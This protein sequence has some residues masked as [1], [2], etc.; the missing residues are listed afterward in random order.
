MEF[1]VSP[2]ARAVLDEAAIL[3]MRRGKFYVG[4]EYILEAL[5]TRSHLLPAEFAEKHMH[6]LSAAL[7]ALRR[8]EWQG[9]SPVTDTTEVY[10]TPRALDVMHEA[11][12]VAQQFRRG[13]TAPAHL[14]LVILRQDTSEV[15]RILDA[16]HVDR[17]AVAEALQQCVLAEPQKQSQAAG[18]APGAPEPAAG[19]SGDAAAEPGFKLEDFTTDLTDAA[20]RGEVSKP[21]GR[22]RELRETIQVLLRKEKNNVIL[23]GNPGVG[24]TKIVEGLAAG[25][26]SGEFR[27]LLGDQRVIELNLAALLSGTQYRGSFE[28]KLI[29]LLQDMERS[30]DKMLFIDEI[31]LIMGAGAT[32]G[33]G[34][35]MANFL[36]PAL[37]RG[38]LKCIGATTPEEYRKFISKDPAIERRFQTVKIDGLTPENTHELLRR[39][40]PG[41]ERHHGVTIGKGSL[42]AAV[43]LAERYLPRREFPD[44]AIDVLDQACARFHLKMVLAETDPKALKATVDPRIA[45]KVTPH[46]IKK[47]VSA[48]SSISLDDLNGRERAKLSNLEALLSAQ[49]IGQPAAIAKVAAPI[50]KS[51]M[52]MA[53]PKRPDASLFFLG[54]TGVGK[55]Q[56]AKELATQIFGSDEL[57]YTFDM[58]E[59]IEAHAVSRLLGAPPGY[60]GHEEDG[61]LYVYLLNTPYCILLFDEIEKAHPQIYDIFLPILDEGRLRDAKGR[62]ISFK[63]AIVLFTSNVGAEVLDRSLSDEENQARLQAELVKHFRPEFLNRMDGFVPFFPLRREDVRAILRLMIDEIRQR[64]AERKIGIRMY[65]S[66]Y[67]FL[68]ERGYDSRFGAREL[69]RAVERYIADAVSELLLQRRFRPGDMIDIRSD[70]KQLSF[71]KGSQSSQVP[72]PTA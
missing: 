31:H 18:S 8:A 71:E 67:Q 16:E 13:Q 44:K 11:T 7:G 25:L 50:R 45:G 53:S 66:A 21:Y 1:Q 4:V 27:S 42:T 14:L 46:D 68:T 37:G 28:S 49:I 23:L 40:K 36:K 52:G 43:L 22:D 38:K 60:V 58:S 6:G 2:E 57:L 64:L 12:R 26:A 61:L 32:D 54:P 15:C 24:K 34:S 48:M 62:E 65:E 63:H 47:V 33:G 30:G 39:L 35:D 10:Y 69:R 59:F 17:P 3:S 9:V 51:K 72:E 5:I 19:G 29:A 20:K 41:F 70:G 55:T 56:L